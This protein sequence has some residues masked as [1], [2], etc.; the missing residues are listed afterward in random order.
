MWFFKK[1]EVDT[2]K[3]NVNSQTTYDIYGEE[4]NSRADDIFKFNLS[5]K[6]EKIDWDNIENPICLKNL[7]CKPSSR[8]KHIVEF[9]EDKEK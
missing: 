5:E 4:S 2:V 9:F 7:N 6:D 1:K 3:V 8:L